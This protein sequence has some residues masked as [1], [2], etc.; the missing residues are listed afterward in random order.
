MPSGARHTQACMVVAASAGVALFLYSPEAA[1]WCAS[2]ALAGVMLT[3][4]HDLPGNITYHYVR[5]YAGLPAEF[6]WKVVWL[7][8]ATLLPHRGFISHAPIISTV[9]RLLYLWLWIWPVWYYLKLPY[10][11]FT[12]NAGWWLLGIGCADAVHSVLDALDSRLG[13]RL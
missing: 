12:V 10:P 2:G 13:G 11:V 7:P 9:I 8:Y 4:D 1:F 6:L 5:K 3:C